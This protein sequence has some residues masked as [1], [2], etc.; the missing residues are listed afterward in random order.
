MR[1]KKHPAIRRIEFI[2]TAKRLFTNNGI[3]ETSVSD[4]VGELNVA[5]GTFY[6]HFESKSQ[7]IEAII[8]SDMDILR[9]T[10]EQIRIGCSD[11]PYQ[12]Q[13]QEI[14][15]VILRFNNTHEQFLN[16]IHIPDNAMLHDMFNSKMMDVFV[17][18]L[19]DI[20][21]AGQRSKEFDIRHP[22]ETA[23]ILVV[24]LNYLN[25]NVHFVPINS[26]GTI[27]HDHKKEAA[28]YFLSKL[29]GLTE[30]QF[31]LDF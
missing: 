31:K 7:L 11:R 30:G 19:F 26:G 10:A 1:I 22:D 8:Q 21:S 4:I 25:D 17:P 20:L 15:N 13:V 16:Y 18:M 28:E 2:D 3:N 5:Q 14:L 6:Y 27:E 24:I 29:L 9:R 12:E 23:E